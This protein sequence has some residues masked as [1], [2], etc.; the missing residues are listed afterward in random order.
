TTCT[1]NND[2]LANQAAPV[3]DT[4]S[5]TCVQCIMNAD[6]GLAMHRCDNHTCSACISDDDCG[7]HGVCQTDGSCA[8]E[9]N[10]IHAISSG[11]GTTAGCGTGGNTPCTL[12]A[13]LAQV[14]TTRNVVKL[15]DAGPYTPMMDNFVIA[16]D[17]TIDARGAVIGRGGNDAPILVVN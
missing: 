5:R 16:K 15:D 7:S 9:D 13:A 10:V 14:S 8:S 6:C 17:V 12:P 11:G 3:C 2:C 4:M 1:G